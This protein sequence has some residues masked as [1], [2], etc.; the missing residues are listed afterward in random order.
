MILSAKYCAVLCN[1]LIYFIDLLSGLDLY[2]GMECRL[3][4]EIYG[5]VLDVSIFEFFKIQHYDIIE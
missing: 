5:R 2:I 1:I 4:S 3:N